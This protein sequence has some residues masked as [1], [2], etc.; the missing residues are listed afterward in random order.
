MIS[1]VSRRH[2]QRQIEDLNIN[3][4]VTLAIPSFSDCPDCGYDEKSAAGKNIACLTCNG[5]GRV[6]SWAYAYLRGRVSWT[7]VGRPRF[8]NAVGTEELGDAVFETRLV[9][10]ELLED[11]RD[12]ERAYIEID[13]RKL[14]VMSVDPNRVEGKTSVVARCEL[15]RND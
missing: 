11:M 1:S 10:K 4:R 2:I 5:T 12:L 6:T 13:R 14:R 3:D 15:I 8:A 7:D 9:H